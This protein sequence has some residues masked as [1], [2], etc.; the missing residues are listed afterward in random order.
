MFEGDSY[1]MYGVAR[2]Y[3]IGRFWARYGESITALLLV[4]VFPVPAQ[5][6]RSVL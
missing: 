1:R 4:F 3:L 2:I 5:T 6:A